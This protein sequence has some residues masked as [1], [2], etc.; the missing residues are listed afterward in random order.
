MTVPR[1]DA[2]YMCH[3]LCRIHACHQ[4]ADAMTLDLCCICEVS[5]LCWRQ[6]V[7]F[8]PK[9]EYEI[10]SPESRAVTQGGARFPE[11]DATPRID[12]Q[13]FARRA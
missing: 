5:Y 13:P 3:E 2:P 9:V 6:Q 11:E 12:V 10:V 1:S 4:N 8:E 7:R